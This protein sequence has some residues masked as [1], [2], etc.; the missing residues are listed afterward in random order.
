VQSRLARQPHQGRVQG[1][2]I[3]DIYDEI[4]RMSNECAKDINVAQSLRVTFSCS[5]WERRTERS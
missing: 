5:L 1:A 4:A 2:A 3:S